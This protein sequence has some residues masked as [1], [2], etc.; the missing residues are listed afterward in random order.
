MN[1]DWWVDVQADTV[2]SG[3]VDE[4][5]FQKEKEMPK[6]KGLGKVVY[7]GASNHWM[8]W[9]KN[10]MQGLNKKALKANKNI[11]CCSNTESLSAFLKWRILQSDVYGCKYIL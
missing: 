7:K 2:G 11:N 6:Y 8:A 1:L 3:S 4:R 5:A 9:K 10:C